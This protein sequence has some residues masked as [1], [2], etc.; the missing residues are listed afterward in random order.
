MAM[1]KCNRCK[2]T[3]PLT[4]FHKHNQLKDGYRG[5]CKVCRRAELAGDP[6]HKQRQKEWY[7]KNKSKKRNDL[8]IKLYGI[9][10]EEY[11]KILAEQNG[12]CK[13]CWAEPTGKSLAVD[14]CHSTGR[15]RGLLCS[16]CNQALGLFNDDCDRLQRAIKYLEVNRE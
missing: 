10:T 2:M 1:K 16:R 4:E 3:K 5:T 9:G 7:Q 13:I 14:H 12:S 6:R 11:E 8:L 15:V